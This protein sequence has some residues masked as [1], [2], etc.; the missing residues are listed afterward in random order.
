MYSYSF[1]LMKE[2]FQHSPYKAPL[3]LCTLLHKVLRTALDC[4]AY[5]SLLSDRSPRKLLDR[6]S[7]L[8]SVFGRRFLIC[9]CRLAG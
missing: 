5:S 6:C 7:G 4:S 8:G 2:G 9:Y 1:A 3:T